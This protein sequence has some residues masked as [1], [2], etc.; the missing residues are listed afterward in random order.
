MTNF[1][2]ITFTLAK[3]SGKTIVVADRYVAH[4][5][6]VRNQAIVEGL[7]GTVLKGVGGFKAEFT[8]PANAKKFIAQAITSVSEDEYKANRK[9]K[10]E[11][12]EPKAKESKS[13][14]KQAKA[15]KPKTDSKGNKKSNA[16]KGKGND[17]PTKAATEE[18][19]E[20]KEVKKPKIELTPSAQKALDKMKIS[21]LN[22]AAS[23]YSI[24]NG[25]AA[26]TFT[27][28]GK[29]ADELKAFMPK[30]KEGLLKS[31]KWANASKTHGLTED[32][33]G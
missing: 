11:E 5:L 30:A 10:V 14:D 23:A 20:V 22:R 19:V 6:Y 9:P 16:R 29:S 8:K 13:A 32:M 31:P 27:A 1:T 2:P 33:L 25:G 3:D 26:T 24:A 28:L 15:S 7:G 12:A 17:A 18:K 4:D 21:V